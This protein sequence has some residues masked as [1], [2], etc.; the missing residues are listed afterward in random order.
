MWGG[1]GEQWKGEPWGQ[2]G[3]ITL[4]VILL[5]GEGGGRRK[6]K[7]HHL[8]LFQINEKHS[9]GSVFSPAPPPNFFSSGSS[10]PSHTHTHPPAPFLHPGNKILLNSGSRPFR[11]QG[12]GRRGGVGSRL[13]PRGWGAGGRAPGGLRA[14][15]CP[16][17]GRG[18]NKAA[19][20]AAAG[21]RWASGVGGPGAPY[22]RTR[23]PSGPGCPRFMATEKGTRRASSA[24]P[25]S[26]GICHLEPVSPLSAQPGPPAPASPPHLAGAGGGGRA[27]P[28]PPPRPGP[29]RGSG[30][31]GGRAQRPRPRGRA[32][33]APERV[34]GGAGAGAGSARPVPGRSS[35]Q[36]GCVW[37]LR[38]K[39]HGRRRRGGRSREEGRG[40][41]AGGGGGGPSASERAAER[42]VRAQS[43]ADG[44]DARRGRPSRGQERRAGA[45]AGAGGA[46]PGARAGLGAAARLAGKVRAGQFRPAGDRRAARGGAGA[47]RSLCARASGAGAEGSAGGAAGGQCSRLAPS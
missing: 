45:G 15:G 37:G 29:A 34:R 25:A 41:G 2:S 10:P 24:P 17:R 26:V 20:A 44:T 18:Q 3:K 39:L 21:R 1:S 27:P 5:G 42:G 4:K 33:A 30:R 47:A 28:P 6:A 12:R 16:A 36:H 40:R 43:S 11:G 19:G 23:G 9:H 46:G 22:L 8:Y 35:A 14:G 32:A 7:P 31:P 38:Q 13:K